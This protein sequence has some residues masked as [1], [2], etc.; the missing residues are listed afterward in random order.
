MEANMM[1]KE[2]PV[3]SISNCNACVLWHLL[4]EKR[5]ED[6]LFF[7]AEARIFQKAYLVLT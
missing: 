1:G 7:E 5:A 2:A 3:Q 6:A 4:T